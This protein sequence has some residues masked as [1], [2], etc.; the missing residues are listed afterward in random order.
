MFIYYNANPYGRLINDC[1]VR[2][3]S[4]A[5]GNSW[6]D[7]YE[8]LSN[9]ARTQGR[10]FDDVMYIDGYLDKMFK[11]IYSRRRGSNLTVEEFIKKHPKGIFLITMR[12]HITC[13]I[14]GIIY[15]TFYPGDRIVWDA[16]EV[17]ERD[18][19]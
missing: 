3:I 6:N 4:L 1:T 19:Y 18:S 8:E 16:Y 13:C 15:D 9:F 14:D 10:M 11:K 2:A 7:T 12:G 17:K 5:T